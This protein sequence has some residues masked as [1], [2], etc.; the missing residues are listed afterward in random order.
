[1]PSKCWGLALLLVAVLLGHPAARAEEIRPALPSA[2]LESALRDCRSAGAVRSEPLAGALLHVAERAPADRRTPLLQF[3]AQADP[4][5]ASPHL[6]RAREALRSLD[7]PGAFVAIGAAAR[8]MPID[9][10]EEA[11]WYRRGWRA[12]HAWLAAILATLAVLFALRSA[13]F[14]VHALGH[15]FGSRTAVVLALVS[16]LAGAFATSPVVGVLALTLLSAP[17]L[18]RRER[19]C[20]AV[21]C[22][23]LASLEVGLHTMGPRALLLD[24][25][26]DSARA[27]RV[28]F[29]TPDP[30]LESRW[31][32]APTRSAT[33]EFLLGIQAR[34]R[35]DVDLAE[36]RYI[37]CLR[38]DSTFV[39]AYVNLANL[40]FYAGRYDRAAAGY[41]AAAI[42]APADPVPRYDLAQAYIRMTHY[43]EA[44][45]ELA[46]AAERGM[47]AAGRRESIWH[48][49]A[50]PVL[51]ATL[52]K[53]QILDLARAEWARQPRPALLWSWRSA[54]WR[55]LHPGVTIGLLV[56][57]VLLLAFGV[58][59]RGTT[60]TCDGCGI[61]LCAHCASLEPAE[62]LCT[63]CVL[64][65][66]RAGPRAPTAEEVP[67]PP[68]PRRV[69]LVSGRWVGVL[70]PGAVDL[71]AGS[72]LRATLAIAAAWVA[73]LGC[74]GLLLAADART[75]AGLASP[76]A[77]L[78]SVGVAAVLVLWLIGL[79]RLRRLWGRKRLAVRTAS[80]GA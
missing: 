52:S 25:R 40:F 35:G 34:H 10:R 54:S 51:D 16:I 15:R 5:L 18:R 28:A 62:D 13:R 23:L 45:G 74:R 56:A 75:R 61:L 59:L 79:L 70:F 68:P 14:A 24:L 6:A 44:D 71:A 17:F 55:D 33:Q 48:D 9:A 8:A 42:F 27:A 67:V 64:G 12:V 19:I 50:L 80:A 3:A 11:G 63:P 7:L 73:L 36:R 2:A 1:M 43:A 49:D 26:S 41:R 46:A 57:T 65:R 20:V 21:V 66:P 60:V 58:R 37:A 72:P 29:G 47:A 31:G 38:R 53:Q 32:A 4:A 69:S 39:P 77:P 76:D 78:L 22:G 30:E